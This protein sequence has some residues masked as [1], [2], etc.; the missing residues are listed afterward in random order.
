MSCLA[1]VRKLT[2]A[3]LV[4]STFVA[5]WPTTMLAQ[6][7]PGAP[8]EVRVTTTPNPLPAGRCAAIWVEIVDNNGYRRT[9]L[10]DGRTVDT[11][12]FR[13]ATSDAKHFQWMS[14][15]PANGYICTGATTGAVATTITVT[16]ADGTSGSVPLANIP[17]GQT[18]R[19]TVFRPQAPLWRP[20]LTSAAPGS[21]ALSAAAVSAASRAPVSG[22]SAGASGGSQSAAAGGAPAGPDPNSNPAADTASGSAPNPDYNPASDTASG[23]APNPNYNPASDTAGSNAGSAGAGVAAGASPSARAA[24]ADAA[25]SGTS[26]TPSRPRPTKR[27]TSAPPSP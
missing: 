17:T 19:P 27:V 3:T 13:Y 18:A 25:S 21:A 8:W 10:Q 23:N 1:H 11:R 5:S 16:M 14:G 26:S 4:A 9:T 7:V 22:V 2:A 6:T 24:G 12:L 15:N 20:G